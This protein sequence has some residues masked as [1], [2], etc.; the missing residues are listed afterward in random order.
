MFHLLNKLSKLA[1]IAILFALTG[2]L[3]QA[4]Y[5]R[6]DRW[7]YP[8]EDYW[9]VTHL[10]SGI[11]QQVL[12]NWDGRVV[13]VTSGDSFVLKAAPGFCSVRLTGIEAPVATN[14]FDKVLVERTARSQEFLS[15]LLLSNE[16]RV[17][18]THLPSPPLRSGLG[19]VYLGTN[20]I[21]LEPI[22]SGNA[23]FRLDFINGLPR[24]EQYR[25]LRAEREARAGDS[26]QA[27]VPPLSPPRAESR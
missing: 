19:L 16:V 10:E 13:K 23:R 5:A 25:F 27:M 9:T 1:A 26:Q 7:Y 3:A 15:G 21:N 2:M 4:A 24:E 12:E 17:V 11:K 6:R 22:R 14:A 20:L 18:V 8:L